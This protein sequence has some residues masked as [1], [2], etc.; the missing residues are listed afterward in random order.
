[1]RSILSAPVAR[2]TALLVILAMSSD[3]LMAAYLNDWEYR[4]ILSK[5]NVW[6]RDW[7]VWK[8]EAS[9]D[10]DWKKD[11]DSKYHKMMVEQQFVDKDSK[12][13][14]V[15]FYPKTYLDFDRL[16][17]FIYG[18]VRSREDSTLGN[19]V[20]GNWVIKD[21]YLIL[22]IESIHAKPYVYGYKL[23]YKILGSQ[24][25]GTALKLERVVPPEEL[26]ILREKRQ[27]VGIQELEN[28][29]FA[30]FDNIQYMDLMDQMA[31]KLTAQKQV[32]AKAVDGAAEQAPEAEAEAEEKAPEEAAAEEGADP[33]EAGMEGEAEEL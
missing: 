1:M 30:A 4:D 23:R 20:K 6:R 15:V 17:H 26:S 27:G 5:N 24:K 3:S 19:D 31:Q 16:G 32:E 21:G 2:L 8:R 33:K 18:K 10:F 9:S 14:T 12:N 22:T 29:P 28:E 7:W 13:C 11:F 25:S